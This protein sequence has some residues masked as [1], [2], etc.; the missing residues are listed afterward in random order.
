M[1]F[2]QGAE[3]FQAFQLQQTTTTLYEQILA[4][5]NSLKE[6]KTII[7]AFLFC[8]TL[9]PHPM[10][11]TINCNYEATSGTHHIYRVYTQHYNSVENITK[12]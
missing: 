7:T 5:V 6:L 1:V 9:L 8:L 3:A 2:L 12:L 11:N 10:C 4:D